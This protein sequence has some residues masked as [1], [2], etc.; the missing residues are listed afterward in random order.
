MKCLVVVALLACSACGRFSFGWFGD[1]D[2]TD[3]AAAG[4][5]AA[6]DA[7]IDAAPVP[8]HE[9]PV[10]SAT[11]SS[12]ASGYDCNH[13]WA[14][15]GSVMPGWYGSSTCACDGVS[16]CLAYTI[17]D[18]GVETPVVAIM[19]YPQQAEEMWVYT[20]LDQ[21]TWALQ[22]HVDDGMIGDVGTAGQ[23]GYGLD[24]KIGGAVEYLPDG[25]TI[26]RYVRLDMA[27]NW[28]SFVG[29]TDGRV[30]EPQ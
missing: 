19:T 4:D 24:A 3:A 13:A 20:S 22:F 5:G 25:A 11:C 27:V 26:A 12:V 8:T 6:I 9:V 29:A 10:A 21:A 7:Q 15:L 1:D 14:T 28:C 30:Y 18:L 16:T 17:A 23:A 2:D